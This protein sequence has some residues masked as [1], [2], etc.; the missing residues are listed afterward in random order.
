MSTELATPDSTAVRGLAPVDPRIAAAI[1]ECRRAGLSVHQIQV[2]TRASRKVID[3]QLFLARSRRQLSDV[4]DQLSARIAPV[5]V[6]VL[7]E[8]LRH[9][10]KAAKK[11]E[12][13]P[14]VRDQLVKILQGLGHFKTH[15]NVRADVRGQITHLRIDVGTDADLP[16]GRRAT[17][18]PGALVHGPPRTASSDVVDAEEID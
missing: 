2:V 5:V 16:P 3:E 7:A 4:D 17:I 15:Q 11:G 6:E 18:A 14:K 12:L 9:D 8:Q 10:L 1:V 13:D